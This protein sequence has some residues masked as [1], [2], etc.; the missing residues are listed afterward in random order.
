MLWWPGTRKTQYR[1]FSMTGEGNISLKQVFGDDWAV[2]HWIQFISASAVVC[3]FLKELLPDEPM[4]GENPTP[5]DEPMEP[6]DV[7]MDEARDV[8]PPAPPSTAPSPMNTSHDTSMRTPVSTGSTMRS[9]STRVYSRSTTPHRTPTA[10]DSSMPTTRRTN[11]ATDSSNSQT[12][13]QP[14]IRRTDFHK[15]HQPPTGWNE[16]MQRHNRDNEARRNLNRT[17]AAPSH[18][19]P[20]PAT[21]TPMPVSLPIHDDDSVIAD[22]NDDGTAST[23]TM[24]P[25]WP[26]TVYYSKHPPS[27]TVGLTGT[28]QC[29]RVAKEQAC[30]LAEN[31]TAPGPFKT[32]SVNSEFDFTEIEF[33]PFMARFFEDL[34]PI[35]F[36][37]VV[38]V[39]MSAGPKGKVKLMVEKNYDSLTTE[40][41]KKNWPLVEAAIRKEIRS[42][43]DMEC[44]EVTSRSKTANICSSRWVFKWKEI[45][46]IR[47]VKARLTIRGY[48]DLAVDAV[49]YAGTASR[50]GQRLINSVSVQRKW[51]LFTSDVS[52]EVLHLRKSQ[53]CRVILFVKL[54]L[55]PLRNQNG[56][57]TNCPDL[58]SMITLETCLISLN[59]PMA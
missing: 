49:N 33:T 42:F 15:P 38:V 20:V 29:D 24:E 10:T 7:D 36:D 8:F 46:G 18:T 39:Y 51:A 11:T 14:T 41:I 4:L 28:E 16:N 37:E 19:A 55:F 1:A 58:L 9:T 30:Y 47:S 27:I 57:L 13:Q 40:D 23:T 21:P 56:I 44:F 3:K 31:V 35:N 52:S 54:L 53:T 17:Q 43:F 5:P 25:D 48:E 45:N 6:P 50:W 12:P 22:S 34:P 59:P 26:D 32:R 2:Q